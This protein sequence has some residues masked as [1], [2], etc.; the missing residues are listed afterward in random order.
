[1]IAP[2]H[3]FGHYDENGVWRREKFCFIQCP[4]DR[5]DCMPPQLNK[6]PEMSQKSE[7]EIAME[8]FLAN[9]GEIQQIARGVQSETATTN[10]WGAPKKKKKV[11]DSDTIAESDE[12]IIA[13]ITPEE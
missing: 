12:L 6:E 4:P 8:E 9:G 3:I 10:F 2:K 13:K 7:Y 1:M 11:E 5:C